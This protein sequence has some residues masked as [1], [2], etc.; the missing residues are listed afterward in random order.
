MTIAT[1]FRSSGPRLDPP[2]SGVEFDVPLPGDVRDTLASVSRSAL[3]P[4]LIVA[5]GES[6]RVAA[7]ALHELSHPN[8]AKAPFIELDCTIYS[9]DPLGTELFGHEHEASGRERAGGGQVDLAAG[10]TLFL[11]H[12]TALSAGAQARLVRLLDAVTQKG[13]GRNGEVGTRLR[14]VA[15]CEREPLGAVEAG[16]LR[17]DLYRELAVFRVDIPPLH[18]RGAAVLELSRG[19]VRL[20]AER[21][22]KP[23]KTL[24]ADAENALLAYDF[25]GNERELR[26]VIERAVILTQGTELTPGDLGLDDIRNRQPSPEDHFFWVDANPGG[27]PPPLDVVDRA[28]VARVL[29]HTAGRRLAAAHLLGISYPTFLKRLRELGFDRPAQRPGERNRA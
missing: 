28:Y 1:D 3:T 22:G 11:D 16:R 14:I 15:G 10:G 21:L 25:P 4:V 5:A 7:R 9:G 19:Y 20:F 24:S 18:A 12:L 13:A 23:V 26:G 2:A 27:V 29:T 6:R 17:D 8:D